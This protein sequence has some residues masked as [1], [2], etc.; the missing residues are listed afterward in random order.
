MKKI[1]SV[2]IFLSLF[3]VLPLSGKPGLLLS[4]QV[5]FLACICTVLFST[6]PRFSISESK[7]KFSSDRNTVW[8]ILGVSCIGQIASLMEWAYIKE[9]IPAFSMWTYVG[10]VMLVGG[11]AFR[12]YAIN[13]LGKYFSTTVQIKNEHRIIT[14]GPYKILRHPSYSGAYIAMLGCA[15][16]LESITGLLIFGIGMLFVYHLRIKT[17][18]QTLIQNFKEDYLNYSKQTWKMFP[19]VW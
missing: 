8:L 5:V 19:M 17:E 10:A 1:I 12:V 7:A 16:F 4:P 18:E 14:A 3:Y 6:Q 11:T 2:I 9:G 13:V 15:V